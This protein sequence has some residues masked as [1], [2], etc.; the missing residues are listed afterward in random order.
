MRYLLPLMLVLATCWASNPIFDSVAPE[1]IQE[2]P[3]D[4]R[5]PKNVVPI[6]YVI[7]LT[8]YINTGDEKNF[9][10]DGKSEID[11]QVKENNITTITFHAKNIKLNSVNLMYGEKLEPQIKEDTLLEFKEDKHKDFIIVSLPNPIN[12]TTKNVKLS[13]NYT[14]VLNDELRG[15]YR[16]SYKKGNEIR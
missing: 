12:T 6:N 1:L 3:D 7:E 14:G 15:F 8:P 13:L 5:L 4:Y 2:V 16:S 11:L 9:T 10:F